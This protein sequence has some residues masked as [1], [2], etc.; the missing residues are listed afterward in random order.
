MGYK[1]K[2]NR[3]ADHVN[4]AFDVILNKSIDTMGQ[5]W[6]RRLN[7]VQIE[8]LSR[9]AVS[10]LYV[11]LLWTRMK[12]IKNWYDYKLFP[13]LPDEDFTK[14]KFVCEKLDKGG[15]GPISLTHST[16]SPGFLKKNTEMSFSGASPSSTAATNTSTNPAKSILEFCFISYHAFSVR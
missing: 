9:D 6:S 11:G 1:C 13:L 7:Q 3:L 8:Y 15:H 2:T 16:V 10:V 5:S 4:Y 12:L 14:D